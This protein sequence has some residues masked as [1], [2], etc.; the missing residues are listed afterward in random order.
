[1]NPL[2]LL[3]PFAAA[4]PPTPPTPPTPP[5][6]PVAMSPDSDSSNSSWNFKTGASEI[7]IQTT[8]NVTFDPAS[9]AVFDLHGRGTLRVT[10]RAGKDI[11]TLIAQGSQITWTVNG[12][13][14]PYTAEAKDW[15]RKIIKARPA[16]PTPPTPPPPPA[17]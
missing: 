10:D 14:Q 16:T 1:M 13:A 12:K 5:S 4:S 2:S 11:R 6:P 8:G 17:K 9:D 3:F 7:Q 15:L